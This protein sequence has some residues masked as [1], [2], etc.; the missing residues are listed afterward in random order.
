MSFDARLSSTPFH[1]TLQEISQLGM[2]DALI[3]DS[4]TGDLK[5]TNIFN[6]IIQK[7]IGLITQKDW[8]S[9]LIIE[10]ATLNFIAKGISSHALH[11]SD[12]EN[13][14]KIASRLG[15]ITDSNSHSELKAVIDRLREQTLDPQF[16]A[17]QA[18]HYYLTHQEQMKVYPEN[19]VKLSPLAHHEIQVLDTHPLYLDIPESV[20]EVA[21]VPEDSVSVEGKIAPKESSFTDLIIAVKST[22]P[23]RTEEK[24]GDQFLKLLFINPDKKST[25][26]QWVDSVFSQIE[27]YEAFTALNDLD[28]LIKNLGL[29]N[30]ITLISRCYQLH[31]LQKS[32]PIETS[33]KLLK[34]LEILAKRYPSVCKEVAKESYPFDEKNVDKSFIAKLVKQSH[35]QFWSRITMGVGV[36]ILLGGAAALGWSRLTQPGFAEESGLFAFTPLDFKIPS[37]N[38]TQIPQW[39]PQELR[40]F[41]R[42]P[43]EMTRTT[44]WSQTDYDKIKLTMSTESLVQMYADDLDYL[45]KDSTEYY[46][47]L[48]TISIA[49]EQGE[50]PKGSIKALPSAI[51]CM[52]AIF[53]FDMRHHPIKALRAAQNLASRLN[54]E[55][56]LLGYPVEFLDSPD[57]Y[58]SIKNALNALKSAQDNGYDVGHLIGNIY[59][60]FAWDMHSK[61]FLK[62]GV[63][64]QKAL[65]VA[66]HSGMYGSYDG[67]L[68]AA[69]IILEPKAMVGASN[70]EKVLLGDL[71]SAV[72]CVEN[73]VHSYEKHS[74]EY[75][76]FPFSTSMYILE[77]ILTK[78]PDHVHAKEVRDDI[79]KT[80]GEQY[81]GYLNRQITEFPKS[82]TGYHARAKHLSML[83]LHDLALKDVERVFEIEPKMK[84]DPDLIKIIEMANRNKEVSPQQTDKS[85]ET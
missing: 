16:C 48:R 47:L 28:G 84:T 54:K 81:L 23:E 1:Q 33:I 66:V 14:E 45:P 50:I 56:F 3:V 38:A 34:N 58:P 10:Q 2:T 52:I 15:V 20:P 80:K 59:K 32:D 77:R 57:K 62:Q 13:I 27:G 82:F 68:L 42:D 44:Y 83:G 70:S 18:D 63:G 17:D 12:L 21:D 60:G 35:M 78:D 79:L 22:L 30:T 69:E 25:I 39:R 74:S 85:N 24:I 55:I 49:Y 46:F 8:T 29:K 7:I 4:K 64:Q 53:E 6:F 11:K 26:V 36:G 65:D 9:S 75:E 43:K 67:W 51:D 73:A 41:L 40:Q 76:L 31:S 19:L 61:S 5:V 37:Y 72:Q 71:E